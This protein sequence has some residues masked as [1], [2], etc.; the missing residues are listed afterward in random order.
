MKTIVRLATCISMVALLILSDATNGFSQTKQTAAGSKA[1]SVGDKLPPQQ[2][3]IVDQNDLQL[4]YSQEKLIILDFWNTSC[5]A[6]VDS[7][8]KLLALQ[9]EFGDKIQIILVNT[10][11][12]PEVIRKFIDKRRALT[13]VDMTLP[14]A[15]NAPQLTKEMFPFSGLP[16]VVWIGK[17]G[18]VLGITSGEHINSKNIR[19][20]IDQ[21]PTDLPK[22][23]NNS[24]L[25]SFDIKKPL[26]INGNGGDLA[27][28]QLIGYSSLTKA[29]LYL[30]PALGYTK[31]TPAVIATSVS[32]QNLYQL[33]YSNRYHFLGDLTLILNNRILLEVEDSIK[34]IAREKGV[35]LPEYLYTYQFV[36]TGQHSPQKIQKKFQS[37]LHFYFGLQATWTKQMRICYVLS[38]SDSDLRVYEEGPVSYAVSTTRIN[39]NKLSVTQ[40]IGRLEESSSKYRYSSYPIVDETG[41]KGELG[42]MYFEVN[43]ENIT[44]FNEKL[45]PFGLKLTIEERLVD[46]L[47]L[48]KKL[49]TN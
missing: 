28:E 22:K 48:S 43:I 41:Y 17:K 49:E 2:L 20:L 30:S 14:M 25:I 11:Q 7:W 24:E 16:H 37:D 21:K 44:H 42:R 15:Y 29:N 31:N 34:Y 35:R 38:R 4:D 9:K 19:A 47:V 18:S 40:F 27:D 39:V 23:I 12:S 46:I 8:P 32:I 5:S 6:C 33:A 13:G 36:G 10:S 1:L 3:T 45:R 26:H